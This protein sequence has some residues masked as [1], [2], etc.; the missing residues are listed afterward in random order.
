MQSEAWYLRLVQKYGMCTARTLPWEIAKICVMIDDWN[1]SHPKSNTQMPAYI[2]QRGSELRS[3]G[4]PVSHC[5]FPNC[6]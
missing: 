6:L 2:T 4:Q 5:L 1:P 3:E